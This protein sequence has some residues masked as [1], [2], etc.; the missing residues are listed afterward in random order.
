MEDLV[1]RY[2]S[3][4]KSF[5]SNS[6]TR[7]LEFKA[8]FLGGLFVDIVFYGVQFFFFSVIYSYVDALGVFTREDVMIFLVI[9]FL[10][11][12]FYMLFFSGNLFNL[13]RWV[14]KGE[15]DFILLKPVNSQFFI[16]CRYV[17]TYS[18]VSIFILSILLLKLTYTYHENS[19]LIINY[20]VCSI[21]LIL[22]VL[23]FYAFEFIISCLA[24]WFRNFSYAGWL[25]GELTK[26]S[27]RP[28][29]IYKK[30]FQKTL[31]SIFPMAMLC[32]VPSR[33][34][35]WGIEQ[36]SKGIPLTGLELVFLQFF[37][38]SIFLWITTVIWKRG[39]KRYESASS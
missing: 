35:L 5:F 11:D 1:R 13:N 17:N 15:L 19:F 39:L 26:Y 2:L 36:P 38:A 29:S 33:I 24:F 6:L 12:T 18:L 32:S 14:V 25:A 23:I 3:L 21:S 30:W 28:D 37:I 16:S 20:I 9:T 8:N 31:F 22:G 4:W 34:L 7:D 27:R 10:S